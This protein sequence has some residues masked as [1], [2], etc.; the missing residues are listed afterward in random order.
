MSM[1]GGGGNTMPYQINVTV[2]TQ[3]DEVLA[4]AVERGQAQRNYRLGTV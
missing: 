4:R 1:S 3:N 2:K